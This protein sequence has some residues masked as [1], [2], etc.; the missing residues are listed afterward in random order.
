M[1]SLLEV[2]Q[3]TAEE[4]AQAQGSN[5][6]IFLLGFIVGLFCIGFGIVLLTG[7][8]EFLQNNAFINGGKHRR[9]GALIIYR[10]TGGQMVV[11]GAL[12][13]LC[14]IGFALSIAWLAFP[15]L[16]LVIALP[17]VCSSYMKRSK[18]FK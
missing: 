15:T 10:F 17:F 16:V 1:R 12:L 18:R 8:K 7:K 9:G 4:L 6:T 13:I 2:S 5:D 11:L 3:Q 14:V